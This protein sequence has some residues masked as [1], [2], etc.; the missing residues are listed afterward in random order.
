MDTAKVL[1]TVITFGLGALLGVLLD[2]NKC[3][4]PRAGY[5]RGCRPT[6]LCL[7][8]PLPRLHVRVRQA[9]DAGPILGRPASSRDSANRAETDEAATLGDSEDPALQGWHRVRSWRLSWTVRR[10]PSST[11]RVLYLNMMRV[12]RG[13][14]M[15]ATAAVIRVARTGLRSPPALGLAHVGLGRHGT[16]RRPHTRNRFLVQARPGQRGLKPRSTPPLRGHIRTTG[17]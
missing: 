16:A 5:P 15:P 10:P 4:L 7:A 2:P 9:H 6:P 11:A 8:G 12:W 1:A 3:Q 17:P 13:M 14:F